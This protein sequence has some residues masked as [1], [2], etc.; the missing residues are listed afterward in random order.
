MVL[1]AAALLAAEQYTI[2]QNSICEDM[3]L[4]Q[5]ERVKKAQSLITCE[6]DSTRVSRSV[7]ADNEKHT[8]NYLR[9]DSAVDP[10]VIRLS[11]MDE[12]SDKSYPIG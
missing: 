2:N 8:K 4:K 11:I 9:A 6:V 1:I 7:N 5:S 3:F 10:T 12:F